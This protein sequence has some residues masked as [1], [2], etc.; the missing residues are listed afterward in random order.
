MWWMYF[1]YLYENRTMKPDEIVLG[2]G[3]GVRKN[4]GGVGG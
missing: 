4:D 1:I 3:G 2:Q